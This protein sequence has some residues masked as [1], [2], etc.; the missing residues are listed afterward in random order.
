MIIYLIKGSW[1]REG[2]LFNQ[3]LVMKGYDLGLPDRSRMRSVGC[4]SCLA[5]FK[6]AVLKSVPL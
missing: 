4:E 3:R 5:Y 1:V 2:F 6:K